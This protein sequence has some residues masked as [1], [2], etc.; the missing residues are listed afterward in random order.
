M[1]GRNC[2]LVKCL[3]AAEYCLA[4]FLHVGYC[5]LAFHFLSLSLKIKKMDDYIQTLT[6]KAPYTGPIDT[7]PRIFM[8]KDSEIAEP[9]YCFFFSVNLTVQQM[10][11]FYSLSADVSRQRLIYSFSSIL[12]GMSCSKKPD[13]FL[14]KIVPTTSEYPPTQLTC[15]L[16]IIIRK[17]TWFCFMHTKGG[18]SG[19]NDAPG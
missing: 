9:V 13:T 14:F 1:P 10:N 4:S 11:R 8:H 16:L 6:G 18:F 3:Q 5:M 7:L 15:Q 12:S 19:V 17:A 2:S